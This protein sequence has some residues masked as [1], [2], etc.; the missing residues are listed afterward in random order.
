MAVCGSTRRRRH[1]KGGR[2]TPTLFLSRARLRRDASVKTLLPLLLCDGLK[3][4][5]QPGH[6]LVWS[7][8]ADQPDRRRDFL[9]REMGRGTFL[10]LSAREPLDRHGLFDMDEPKPFAPALACGDRLRFSLRA[11]P[12]I[13]RRRDPVHPRSAKHDVVMDALRARSKDERAEF[14]RSAIREQG[15]AWLRRQGERAGFAI[16]IEQVEIDGY[17]QHRVE[18]RSSDRPMWFSTLDFDGLLEVRDAD[19]FMSSVA[20]GFGAA[21]AYGCGL[22]LIR[23]A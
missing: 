15:F 21:K 18:R 20:H 23:R 5:Q 11:N 3:G 12:V 4:S 13:R 10:L 16:R 14:R 2:V 22:M 9:W 7:L 6:H 8:F 1:C 17:Q 19:T